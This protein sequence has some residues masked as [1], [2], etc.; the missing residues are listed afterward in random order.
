M[1]RVLLIVFFACSIMLCGCLARHEKNDETFSY[2]VTNVKWKIMEQNYE[3]TLNDFIVYLDNTAYMA[4]YEV[5]ELMSPHYSLCDMNGDAKKD[6]IIH[7]DNC[8]GYTLIIIELESEYYGFAYS[9]RQCQE[10]YS[11]GLILC[12]GGGWD[13]YFRLRE[14]GNGFVE[15]EVESRHSDGPHFLIEGKEV[16][17]EEYDKWVDDNCRE[18]IDFTENVNWA[19]MN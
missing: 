14:S 4:G 12:S 1:K 15:E 5:D 8:A 6:I 7:I 19:N 17:M 13:G 11:N 3:G 9:E 2:D 10:I 16:S 18:T